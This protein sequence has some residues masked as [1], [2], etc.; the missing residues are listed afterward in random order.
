MDVCDILQANK[1]FHFLHYKRQ[2]HGPFSAF[3]EKTH[4]TGKHNFQ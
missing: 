4:S 1:T 2:K 3:N